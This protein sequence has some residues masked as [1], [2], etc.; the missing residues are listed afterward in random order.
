MKWPVLRCNDKK[1]CIKNKRI[2]RK[3]EQVAAQANDDNFLKYHLLR[4]KRQLKY[5]SYSQTGADV[6]PTH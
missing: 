5:I 1:W 4:Q 6:D 2:E 3:K